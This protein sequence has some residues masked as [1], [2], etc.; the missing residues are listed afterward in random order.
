MDTVVDA[1][2]RLTGHMI[3]PRELETLRGRCLLHVSDTPSSFYGDLERLRAFLRPL[4]LI[5]TGDLADDVKL[6]LHP[7]ELGLYRRKAGDLFRRLGTFPEGLFIVS[8][9]HDRPQEIRRLAPTATVIEGGA[10]I[11]PCGLFIAVAHHFRNL[12]QPARPFN[13]Y[14][15]SPSPPPPEI[16]GIIFLNGLDTLSAIDVESG[17]VHSIAYPPY[18]NGDRCRKRK[19]GL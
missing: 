19:I 17:K 6:E 1:I 11:R 9:N 12:P 14:G 15:H 3:L 2:C 10:V 8:G 18:V 4:A 16:P 7:G 13:L 5:H